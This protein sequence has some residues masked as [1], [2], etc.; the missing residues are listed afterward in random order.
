MKALFSIIKPFVSYKHET[1]YF[2]RIVFFR[3]LLIFFLRRNYLWLTQNKDRKTVYFCYARQL[4]QCENFSGITQKW[5]RRGVRCRCSLVAITTP[6]TT[7]TTTSTYTPREATKKFFGKYFSNFT[8]LLLL[9]C[10]SFMSYIL[11]FYYFSTSFLMVFI[12][13]LMHGMVH[14]AS[15]LES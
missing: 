11:H 3:H 8:I 2:F 6:A 15:H 9:F 12:T 5:R 14:F 1:F 4:L 13:S 7:T 10:V